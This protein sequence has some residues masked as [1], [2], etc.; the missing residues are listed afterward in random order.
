MTIISLFLRKYPLVILVSIKMFAFVAI[1][2]KFCFVHAD[3]HVFPSYCLF[4][5]SILIF[6]A[7]KIVAFDLGANT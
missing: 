2:L 7:L 5:I 4:T 1:F 3:G 6:S